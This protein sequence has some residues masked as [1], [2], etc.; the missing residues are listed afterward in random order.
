MIDFVVSDSATARLLQM[1]SA[2]DLLPSTGGLRVSVRGGGCSGL[3]YAMDWVSGP[4][5]GDR[6]FGNGAVRVYVEQ[7]SMLFLG[8]SELVFDSGLMSS[9]FKIQ[10]PNAKTTCGCGESFS[11]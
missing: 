6:T 2:G 3:T 11:T 9:G 4:S 5:E 8:G 7:K 1:I 10:N